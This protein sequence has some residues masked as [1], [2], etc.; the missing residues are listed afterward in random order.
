[1]KRAAVAI[2]FALLAG[3]GALAQARPATAWPVAVRD[4]AGREDVDRVAAQ[5]PN[6]AGMVRRRLAAAVEARDEAAALAA[7]R[8]L[9]AMGAGLSANARKPAEALVGAK[10]MAPIAARFERNSKPVAASRVHATIPAGHDLVEGVAWDP[11]NGALYATTVVNHSLLLVG[12]EGTIIA[13]SGGYGS[14]L[15]VAF[16]PA[17]RRV[18]AASASLP[19]VP[20]GEDDWT[21]LISVDPDV[22]FRM[23]RYAAPAGVEATPGDVAVAKDGNVYASDGM[24]GAVYRCRPGC[25]ALETLLAPGTLFSAQ[26]LVLSQDQRLLYIADRRYGIAALDRSN[27]RLFQ[28]AGDE[29][30]M[31]DGIDGLAVHG[32]DLIAIQTAY[33]PARIIRLRLSQD[34]LRVVRLD[35]L[36]RAN[37][38]WGEITLGTVAGDRLLYVGNAQWDRY[39][40]GKAVAGKSALPTPIRSL[41][42]R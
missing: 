2:L 12:A 11:N 41:E 1:M 38:E 39:E 5:F 15:G 24:N 21:G 25:T 6:S 23:A 34:G 9:A 18:W 4:F 19:D 36:E 35:L 10:A 20:K 14:L 30:M 33:A 37:P 17:R 22:P 32:R 13:S 16:D 40:G 31:L 27:G 42:L 26:G 7:L 29:T 28:V 3:G 8:Q